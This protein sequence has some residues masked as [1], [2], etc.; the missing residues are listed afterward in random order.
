VSELR[1]VFGLFVQNKSIP[2]V[3]SR[4]PI[5]Y[6][7][8]ALSRERDVGTCRVRIQYRGRYFR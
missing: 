4:S 2:C 8:C 1:N 5:I 3:L 6:L 7:H